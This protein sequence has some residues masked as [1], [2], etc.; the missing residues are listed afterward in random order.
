MNDQSSP[1][2]LAPPVES[3][4]D[5][6]LELESMIK[7][8]LATLDRNRVELKKL[9]EM[10][11]SA[12]LNDEPYRLAA[13]KAKEPAKEKGKA[14]LNVMQN[15]A[16]KQIAD[17]VK[18]MTQENKELAAAQSEYLREYARLS[19]TNEIEGDDGEVR[20]IIYVAKLVKK[21]KR[22]T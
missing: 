1:Q 9:K 5:T 22:N 11:E 6:V 17:K 18:D 19:G 15:S 21:A 16:T 2:P 4:A 13:E 8:N 7:S 12:L 20:E 3:G 10:L 14:K